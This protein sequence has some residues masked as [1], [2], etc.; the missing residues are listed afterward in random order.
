MKRLLSV[1]F[2]LL[3]N[4]SSLFGQQ[5]MVVLDTS[6]PEEEIFV[7]VSESYQIVNGRFKQITKT[8]TRQFPLSQNGDFIKYIAGTAAGFKDNR[9]IF[10]RP[11]DIL[12]I[13]FDGMKIIPTIVNF[14]G[15]EN[16]EKFQN[17]FD[18][19]N[20]GFQQTNQYIYDTENADKYLGKLYKRLANQLDNLD[21]YKFELSEEYARQA[22]KMIVT[23]AV[24]QALNYFIN[25]S[26]SEDYTEFL[27]NLKAVLLLDQ[28]L[29]RSPP[30]ELSFKYNQA[31]LDYC[32]YKTLMYTNE[33]NVLSSVYKFI[34]DN[35]T[36]DHK[37][38]ALTALMLENIN[39]E[40]FQWIY[41]DD[42]K[43][44]CNNANYLLEVENNILMKSY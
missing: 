39:M 35:L 13:R 20:A 14:S 19:I 42:Y 23:E 26:P 3:F 24:F 5:F 29:D 16:E 2:L 12:L 37:E 38:V 6:I 18:L 44:Q 9:T 21:K 11:N 10:I 7:A 17:D 32:K 1:A 28:I 31:L 4:S 43:K 30:E 40:D 22:E 41:Y 25:S 36:D 8:R 27:A 33:Y 15:N 34:T